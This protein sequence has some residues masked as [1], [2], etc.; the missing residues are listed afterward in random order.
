[1]V[2]MPSPDSARLT[3]V[4]F[5]SSRTRK[6]GKTS[7]FP[8][9][10]HQSRSYSFIMLPI[11]KL[12]LRSPSRERATDVPAEAAKSSSD[13]TQE[14]PP[15][16]AWYYRIVQITRTNKD[17]VCEALDPEDPRW[18]FRDQDFDEDLS[19]LDS[20][21]YDSRDIPEHRDDCDWH[22]CDCLEEKDHAESERSYDG[23]DADYYYELK[24]ERR[25]RKWDLERLRGEAEADQRHRRAKELVKEQLVQEVY[26]R[27]KKAIK[28]GEPSPDLDLGSRRGKTFNL[29]S[30]NHVDYCFDAE[31]YPTK[32]V[33]FYHL[34]DGPEV[35]G[36][37]Y[38]NT[39]DGCDF[40]PFLFPGKIGCEKYRL[41]TDRG[42]E[43]SVKFI[44]DDHV[45][46][47]LDQRIA[48]GNKTPDPSAPKTFKFMGI[49]SDH[50][51]SVLIWKP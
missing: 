43:I 39:N 15:L 24:A 36:R 16:P 26:N 34:D 2:R 51:D 3:W 20:E 5:D 18:N 22:D 28:A 25:E 37:V 19:E 4:N 17:K 48:F 31:V 12:R 27:L 14:D 42:S 41:E 11:E 10:H 45:I 47:K 35:R 50:P 49:Q 38:L 46:V 9:K 8:H 44:S 7:S 30:V 32:Y 33:E 23:S 29:F 21:D 1:M 6:A 13:G 40:G